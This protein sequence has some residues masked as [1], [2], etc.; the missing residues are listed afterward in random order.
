VLAIFLLV[1]LVIAVLGH[2]LRRRHGQGSPGQVQEIPPYALP[3]WRPL[4]RATWARTRDIFTI[5]TPLLVGGSVVLALLAHIGADRVINT[6]LTPLTLWW[7]GLPAVLGVPLVFGILRK[8]L[9]LLMVFQALGTPD[10]ERYLDTAQL[11]IFLLFLA[12]Y[13]PC[14]STFAVMLRTIGRRD[15]MFAVSLSL[16]IAILVGGVARLALGLIGPLLA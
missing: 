3:R 13:M 1:M 15:A 16:G 14:I 8:E 9:S 4:A 12:F 2:V 10:I 6:L 7:L 5:V 11:F